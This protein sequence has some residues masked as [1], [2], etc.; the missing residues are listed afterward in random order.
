MFPVPAD[1]VD[2]L[3][4]GD[5][6]EAGLVRVLGDS[7]RSSEPGSPTSSGRRAHGAGRRVQYLRSVTST[8]SQV[9][10]FHVLARCGHI[11]SL[12]SGE[13]SRDR[14]RRRGPRLGTRQLFCG[15]HHTG[16]R[17]NRSI[18]VTPQ[19]DHSSWRIQ[20]VLTAAIWG[21]SFVFIKV[22]GR[23]WP[24]VWVAFGRIT[25]GAITLALLMALRRERYP[26]D[27][28]ALAALPGGSGAV[29]RGALHLRFGEQHIFDRG[30]ALERDHAALGPGGPA[31]GLP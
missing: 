31:R 2:V 12:P 22:L 9:D 19:C 7:S 28:Q 14:T 13:W 23:H 26:S 18:S 17:H 4:A 24:A 5:R 1:G 21:S 25:V 20:F 6:P 11:P 15:H 10:V 27:P 30:R 16:A 3:G 8:S 29:Q